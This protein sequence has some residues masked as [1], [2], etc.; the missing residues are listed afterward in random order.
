MTLYPAYNLDKNADKIGQLRQSRP[1]VRWA[2]EAEEGQLSDVFECGDQFVIALLTDINETEYRPLASMESEL[3]TYAMNRKKAQM[4]KDDLK[5]VTSLDEAAKK[6]NT[7][8]QTAENVTLGGYTFGQAGVEPAAIG[9]A[10]ATEAG[11]L[12][13]PVEGNMGV[14][15]LVAG[16]KVTAEG[17]FD[18]ANEILQASARFAYLPYQ[19]LNWVEEH[20]D[21]TDNR[22]NFQ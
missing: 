8:V 15:M 18:E 6:L 4:I 17:E 3:Q 13:Q 14:I 7:T 12:S 2:F 19:I 1:I 20:A 10:F 9:A 22:A 11:Q 5:G 21:V 16:N